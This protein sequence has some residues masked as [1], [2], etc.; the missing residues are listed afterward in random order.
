M[1]TITS[2]I[3]VTSAD[4]WLVKY[5]NNADNYEEYTSKSKEKITEKVL[6]E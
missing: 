5:E 1:L 3:A 6:Y 2:K 4:T